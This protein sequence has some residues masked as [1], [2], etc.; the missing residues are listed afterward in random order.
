MLEFMA[1]VPKLT[2]LIKAGQAYYVSARNAGRPIGP[3]EVA[4]MIEQLSRDWHPKLGGI[5]F[6]DD[7][8][9]RKAGARFMAGI[10]CAA[11]DSGRPIGGKQ[12]A[13]SRG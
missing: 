2:E 3:D 5:A 8:G 12:G 13:Q 10:A 7:V 11:V 1:L 9:T 4:P 6:L